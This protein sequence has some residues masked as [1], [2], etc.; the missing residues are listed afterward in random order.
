CANW[1][2]KRRAPTADRHH[3]Q[4]LDGQQEWKG[5]RRNIAHVE[6][7]DGASRSR[8]GGGQREDLEFQR[9]YRHTTRRRAHFAC[10]Q[11]THRAA[12]SRSREIERTPDRECRQCPAHIGERER[13]RRTRE[14]KWA[15][16]ESRNVDQT[17]VAAGDV[18]CL[19][20]K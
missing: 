18:L 17:N 9:A 4:E 14:R 11:R 10:G 2:S 16:S 12:D 1:G 15:R 19:T 13:L 6:S 8:K 7:E 20:E 5:T 3:N